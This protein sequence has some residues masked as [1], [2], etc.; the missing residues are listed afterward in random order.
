M[1]GQLLY[2]KTVYNVLTIMYCVCMKTGYLKMNCVNDY[3]VIVSDVSN[4]TMHSYTEHDGGAV[5]DQWNEWM[6]KWNTGMT[7][8]K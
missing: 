8:L 4:H 1:G 6:V 7:Q 5:K 3:I 2:Y